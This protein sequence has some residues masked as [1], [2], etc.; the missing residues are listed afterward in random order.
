MKNEERIKHWRARRE[1]EAAD[2]AGFGDVPHE[3]AAATNV[4]PLARVEPLTGGELLDFLLAGIAA[5]PRADKAERRQVYDAFALQLDSAGEER[6]LSPE[7]IELRGRQLRIA[8]RMLESDLRES[9]DIF[10]PGYRPDGL[11]EAIQRLE[12]SYKRRR[13]RAEEDAARAARREAVLADQAFPV[14]VHTDEEPD[15]VHIRRHLALADAG[16]RGAHNPHRSSLRVFAAVFRHQF[17]LLRAESRIALLWV[18]IG[19]AVLLSLISSL[20][21][22]SGSHYILGMDVPTFSMLGA[23]TWIMFRNI[24]F[25]TSTALYSQRALLNLRPVSSLTIG[26]AQGTIYFIIYI[27]VFLVL[28][29]G[30]NSIGAFS[31]PTHWFRFLCWVGAMG[32]A[33]IAVGVLFGAVAAVWPYFLRFAP[34][35]ERALQIFSSVFFVS[36]QLPEQY[37]AY[38]LW[39]PFAHALQLMRSAYFS[40][41]ESQ[42]ASAEYLLVWLGIIIFVALAAYRSVEPRREPM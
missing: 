1:T 36:E 15:L 37:R 41:Y 34:I 27:A 4:G 39:S 31:L 33:G 5:L 9:R 11:D 3:V 28:I 2:H 13:R 14:A 12:D 16:R 38:V 42:D 40:N 18:F 22:L 29:W 21:I 26:L 8:I 20:Y 25:R 7:T 19:P 35:I 24:I 17:R 6:F 23:T 10:A 32:F 30:G